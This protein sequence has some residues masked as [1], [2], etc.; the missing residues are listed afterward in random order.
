[1]SAPS[2]GIQPSGSDIRKS[3]S[4]FSL[5]QLKV[6]EA[7]IVED[8][9]RGYPRISAFLNSDDNFLM[10]RK[11]G[12]IRNRLLLDQ[13]IELAQ[14][15]EKV[16]VLDNQ[17]ARIDDSALMARDLDEKWDLQVSQNSTL[18]QIAQKLKKY[19]MLWQSTSST[20]S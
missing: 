2:L 7:I 10:Y 14:L 9:P 13:Q 20:Y 11:F 18:R 16:M 8:H 5:L 3:K 4:D 6:A 19:G 17:I 15:E 12:W 1:M